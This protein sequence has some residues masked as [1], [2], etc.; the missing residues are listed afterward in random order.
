MGTTTV[1]LRHDTHARLK[2][3]KR[4]M[5][6]DELFR[7]LLELVPPEDIDRARKIKAKAYGKWQV[8]T[9]RRIRASRSNKRLF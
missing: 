2:K 7:L 8:E 5:T 3:A 9:A 1:Q 6:F 4:D